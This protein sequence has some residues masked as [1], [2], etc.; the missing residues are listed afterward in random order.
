[1]II[2]FWWF[3]KISKLCLK[4][5]RKFEQKYTNFKKFEQ[6]YTNFKKFEQKYTIGF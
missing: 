2:T 5:L 6:K 4:Y 3:E 1:M